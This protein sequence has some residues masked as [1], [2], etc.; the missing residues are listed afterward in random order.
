MLKETTYD[1][2]KEG[3]IF[4]FNCKYV[5]TLTG[6]IKGDKRR[7]RKDKEGATEIIDIYGCRHVNPTYKVYPYLTEKVYKEVNP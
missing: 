6:N 2:L 5:R 4:S 1:T 3:D 7:Y